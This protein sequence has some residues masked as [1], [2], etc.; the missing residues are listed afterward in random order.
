MAWS[1]AE[2]D[3]L[4]DILFNSEDLWRYFLNE[5]VQ[6]YF[7]K[8]VWNLLCLLFVLALLPSD[9]IPLFHINLVKIWVL[10]T[11]MCLITLIYFFYYFGDG[12]SLHTVWSICRLTSVRQ[13]W[14]GA[15]AGVVLFRLSILVDILLHADSRLQSPLV[16]LLDVSP[17]HLSPLTSN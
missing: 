2:R 7:L 12:A 13:A 6:R 17:P 14:A 3:H 5:S 4:R 8:F 9:G 16:I 1:E 15:G 11:T 10:V